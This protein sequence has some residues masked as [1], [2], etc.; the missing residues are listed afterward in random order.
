MASVSTSQTHNEACDWSSIIRAFPLQH[1]RLDE[2]LELRPLTLSDLDSLVDFMVGD[3]EMTWT[4]KSWR[5]ENVEYLLSVRLSH[6]EEYGFGPYGVLI[7][8][9]L[10]G[11]SG[12]QVWPYAECAIEQV[13]Y[14]ARSE[15]SKGLA[16]RLLKWGIQQARDVA[17]VKVLYAATR[18]DNPRS[19]GITRKL[20]F[21]T[22]GEGEHFGYPS[23]FWEL[24]FSRK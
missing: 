4:Q 17:G 2:Q 3:A 8:G 12:V 7:R 18:K 15:W 16:T 9:A 5:R 10:K 24:P 14:I 22:I 11:M 13:A 21:R 1:V 6:Y 20:G 19:I 23:L